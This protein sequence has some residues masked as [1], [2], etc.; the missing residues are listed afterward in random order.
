MVNLNQTI[1]LNIISQNYEGLGVAKV[2]DLVVFVDGA[3]KGETVKAKITKVTK[4]YAVAKLVEVIKASPNR[5]KPLC[6]YFNICGGC[7]LLHMDYVAGLNL[8]LDAFNETLRKIGKIDYKATK[9]YGMEEPHSYRNKIQMPAGTSDKNKLV[10]G[11]YKKDSH[12][13]VAI[14]D[15]LVQSDNVTK[16][17][18]FVKNVCNELNIT[19]YNEQT[20]TGAIRHILVRENKNSELMVV[21]VTNEEKINNEDILVEKIIN[22][23]GNVKSIIKN[24]NTMHNNVIL[25]ANSICLFGKDEIVDEILG[26]KFKISH[27]SFFQINRRQTEK[28]YSLVLDNLGENA[29]E[30]NVID[31]YCGV[32]S[33]SLCLAK[34]VKHVYGI[35]IV[36]EAI[37]DAKNNAVLN[38]ITNASFYVGKVEDL[39]DDF[40]DKNIDCIVVDP[41]RKG[42]EEKVLRSIINANIKKIIYVSCNPAT[43]A[44]DLGILNGYYDV[45]DIS[46]VDMFCMTNG[47]ESI[48]TLSL[49]R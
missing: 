15:C 33:I 1:Q 30:M 2:D 8:K 43:L 23:F 19:A 3:I 48:A 17:I 13:V 14:E 26:L 31:G 36:E 44:R 34:K 38:N 32:G 45:K 4:N 37:N 29:K 39:I 40:I 27:K 5:I 41:P 10:F 16:V 24:I 47:V 42:I 6:P 46:L 9:I 12:D 7:S 11:Y 21:I 25:G 20:K 28:L 22:K 49:K 35:E 18:N